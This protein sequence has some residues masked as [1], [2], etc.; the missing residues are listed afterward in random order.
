MYLSLI[1]WLKNALKLYERNKNIGSKMLLLLFNGSK[2]L[3]FK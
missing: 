2:M 1:F 3:I